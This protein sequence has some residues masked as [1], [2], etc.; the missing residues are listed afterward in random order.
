M[1][2]VWREPA[3]GDVGG[4]NWRNPVAPDDLLARG[5][6]REARRLPVESPQHIIREGRVRQ[7]ACV[8]AT[9]TIGISRAGDGCPAPPL[10]PVFARRPRCGVRL[11]RIMPDNEPA[12]D[13]SVP[14]EL[15]RTV[16]AFNEEQMVVYS[17][18]AM[19][20]V[21]GGG[22]GRSPMDG[23][24]RALVTATSL[25]PA[26]RRRSRLRPRPRGASHPV[27]A[28]G[29]KRCEDEAT[30]VSG[31]G[32]GRGRRHGGGARGTA[33]AFCDS[34]ASRHRVALQFLRPTR[35]HFAL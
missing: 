6:R 31:L 20:R 12:H 1:P 7:A 18:L 17:V 4:S 32:P 24:T 5:S 11:P 25:S 2:D 33:S 8:H 26:C 22:Y 19:C 3:A 9:G 23:A 27:V 34:R 16:P 29:V 13:A 21:F 30:L 10:Q 35:N 15:T 14:F 28:G